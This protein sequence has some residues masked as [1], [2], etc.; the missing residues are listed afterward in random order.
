MIVILY[1]KKKK[2]SN[3]CNQDMENWQMTA[4]STEA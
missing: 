3:D 4:I 2:K 1:Q